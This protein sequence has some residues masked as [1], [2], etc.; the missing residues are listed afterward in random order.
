MPLDWDS[1]VAF[2][3]RLQRALA[4]WLVHV[5]AER[6]FARDDADTEADPVQFDVED[7]EIFRAYALETL[8]VAF[9]E[10]FRETLENAIGFSAWTS[11]V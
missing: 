6:S 4:D 11:P 10:E 2:D 9:T 1:P 7:F 8:H 5:K 3:A